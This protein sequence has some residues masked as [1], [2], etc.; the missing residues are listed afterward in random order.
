M[1]SAHRLARDQ[2][3]TP[4]CE[5]ARE[6]VHR[7][8]CQSRSQAP[9]VIEDMDVELTGQPAFLSSRRKPSGV[10]QSWPWPLAGDDHG[11]M[12]LFERQKLLLQS[13]RLLDIAG[14]KR[15]PGATSETF[16]VSRRAGGKHGRAIV[17]HLAT[18]HER[19]LVRVI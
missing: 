7:A 3:C 16:P 14:K 11:N 2:L 9:P 6:N 1:H 5:R 13:K 12:P 17:D 8:V 15:V 4:L 19:A 10:F 18:C